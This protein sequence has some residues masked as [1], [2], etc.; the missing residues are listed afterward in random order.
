MRSRDENRRSL[1]DNTT[2][3]E[4][5]PIRQLSAPD[6]KTLL[7]SGTAIKLVA[8]RTVEERAIA[9]IHG[10]DAWSQLVDTSVPRY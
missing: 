5:S 7:T 6:L 9:T 10:I 3:H 2:A 4:P 8:V 1:G